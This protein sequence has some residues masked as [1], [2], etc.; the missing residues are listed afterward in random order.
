MGNGN[1]AGVCTSIAMGGPGAV[2]WMWI[3]ATLGMATKMVE[4][5]LGH[6]FRKILPNGSIAGGPMYYLRDGLNLPWLAGAYALFMAGKATFATTI[7]QS[8]SIAL[9]LQSELNLR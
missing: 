2:F 7:I 6:K 5:I 3:L 1:I 8:N 4:A 9:A